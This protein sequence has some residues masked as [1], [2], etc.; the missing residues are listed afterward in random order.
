MRLSWVTIGLGRVSLV[1][2]PPSLNRSPSR[3]PEAPIRR[4][5]AVAINARR[6]TPLNIN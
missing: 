1:P 5:P 2:G 4:A 6:I 3:K